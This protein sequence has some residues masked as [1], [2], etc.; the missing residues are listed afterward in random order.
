M[1]ALPEYERE[2]IIQRVRA[3]V[4]S[5]QKRGVRFGPAPLDEAIAR[6]RV[7]NARRMMAEGK[8]AALTAKTLGWSKATLYRYLNKYGEGAPEPEGPVR[9]G[10][11]GSKYAARRRNPSPRK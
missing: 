4:I 3:G 7:A 9:A 8:S 1:A 11:D 2:L 5:A 10:K 6:E